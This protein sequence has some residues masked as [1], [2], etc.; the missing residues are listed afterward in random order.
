MRVNIALPVAWADPLMLRQSNPM[1]KGSSLLR[2]KMKK[3]QRFMAEG[4]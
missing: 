4:G 2:P 1:I 3:A